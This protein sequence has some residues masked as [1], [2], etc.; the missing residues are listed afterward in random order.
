M[1][2]LSDI[3]RTFLNYFKNQGHEVINSSPVVPQNDPTLMFTNAGMV[4]FKD[5]F[6]G[7]E[8]RPYK[9]A[10]SSQ[11]CIRAGGKHN[12]LDNVGY[13]ARHHT[14]FEMLGN[15]SFG[16]YFKEDAIHFAWEMVTKEF[17][18]P[19]DKL[20]VT[21][22]HE[23]TEA[24]NL[25][26]KI[27]GFSD[28][29]IIKIKTADNFWSMGDTGPCG[30]CTEIFY[31]HGD[32]ILGG[33]PGSRDED[34]DR[35]IEIWNLVFMQYEQISSGNRINL[36]NPSIDTGMGLERV[37]AVLQGV[38]NNYQIDLF[39]NLIQSIEDHIGNTGAIQSYRV[40]ADHLRACSFMVADGITPSN[41]GRGYVLRRILRRAMRHAHLLGA[42]EPL[43]H[44]LVPT[45]LQTMGDAYPELN[46][47]KEFIKQTF[48]GEEEKFRQT[49]DKGLRLLRDEKESI[50]QNILSGDV[51]F[52]L[53][54]TYGFPF[55]LTQDIL[56]Q[57]NISVDV[58]GF[59]Q[60]MTVQKERARQ[61]W[62]GSGE[63]SNDAIYF[64]LKQTI[65]TSEFLGYTTLT[66]EAVVQ[67]II[68]E[69]VL[70]NEA[71][72]GDEV[73]LVFNQT[74]FY[75][76]SGGQKGDCGEIVSDDVT[77]Q[78]LDVQKKLDDIF[79]HKS[80]ILKGTIKKGDALKLIVNE[81]NSGVD[82]GF[83]PMF[84]A[85]SEDSVI[86]GGNK[87]LHEEFR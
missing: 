7:K 50:R 67:A 64:D 49:L 28:D 23:D 36:P 62:V 85:E 57:E 79:V 48:K 83:N 73:L 5:V 37:A 18:L 22:Y 43:M 84:K 24:F 78:V 27:A 38:H 80:V 26:K 59:N 40:I 81:E 2:H 25:W 55:D 14:F 61:A 44:K 34:G 12:D 65:G 60:A 46:R 16:D 20:L 29:K 13:T 15:F 71:S 8:V 9:R 32:T 86:F 72:K 3:R 51:A 47:A 41:E 58:D 45:L 74:P 11:K 17:N 39:K 76:E 33:P 30:P 53:Y 54:D 6:T 4:Q 77:V 52:K 35:F 69:G 66:S 42:K 68:K 63:T 19:K 75:A 87:F 70:L 1:K 21:V 56:R 31:D 10:T 82:G